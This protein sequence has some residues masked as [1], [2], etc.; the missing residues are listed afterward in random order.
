MLLTEFFFDIPMCLLGTLLTYIAKSWFLDRMVWLFNDCAELYGTSFITKL[1]N[2]PTR[3]DKV[4][5][6]AH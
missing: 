2:E 1:L 6:H 5:P 3:E 4:N